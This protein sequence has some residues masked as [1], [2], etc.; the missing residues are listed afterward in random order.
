MNELNGFCFTYSIPATGGECR[1]RSETS[2]M[3][4][5]LP[6]LRLSIAQ[7]ETASSAVTAIGSREESPVGTASEIPPV[8]LTEE[9][10]EG[11]GGSGRS[12]NGKK[13]KKKKK[14]N[15]EKL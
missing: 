5:D 4:V 15:L 11:S 3:S 9:L 2:L 13:N 6:P 1:L 12:S 7:S 14:S 8:E 10:E